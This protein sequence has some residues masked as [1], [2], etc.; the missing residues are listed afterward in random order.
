MITKIPLQMI[1]LHGD[2]F[3]VAVTAYINEK[4]VR[5]ILDT[6]ASRTVFDSNRL[7]RFVSQP[8]FQPNEQPS[9]GLGTNDMPSNFFNLETFQLGD[10]VIKNY[11]TL[12]IDMVHINETYEMLNFPLIDGV[13]GGDLLEKHRAGIDYSSKI[14]TLFY[15][16]S[17]RAKQE[18]I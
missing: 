4:P 8:D 2:G 1:D 16:K 14:L 5:M 11:L 15:R 9:T 10:L 18:K 13:V 12:A 6:G 3:H 7:E 17:R